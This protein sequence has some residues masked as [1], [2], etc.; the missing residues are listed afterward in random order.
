MYLLPAP[1]P[2]YT[3]QLLFWCTLHDKWDECYW[4]YHCPRHPV[5]LTTN[6]YKDCTCSNQ[7]PWDSFSTPS[8]EVRCK[9]DCHQRRNNW[10]KTCMWCCKQQA[11]SCTCVCHHVWHEHCSE[12][13]NSGCCS[14]PR[15]AGETDAKPNLFETDRIDQGAVIGKNQMVET[16]HLNMTV[17]GDS[18]AIDF[19]HLILHECDSDYPIKPMRKVGDLVKFCG[20]CN[21][22]IWERCAVSP[23]A[24]KRAAQQASR[25]IEE[26]VTVKLHS[27]K[28]GRK[29]GRNV[30]ERPIPAYAATV[31]KGAK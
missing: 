28:K 24:F 18:T 8:S 31:G 29:C 4:Q 5:P 16:I 13:S 6:T 27:W 17:E 20:D 11:G 7:R 9:C 19:F 1:K 12:L 22:I 21:G 2:T 3:A 25:I 14:A 10:N 30:V 15:R 23:D 26:D